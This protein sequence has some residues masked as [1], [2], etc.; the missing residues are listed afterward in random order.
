M[1]ACG[2]AST[3]P[4][5]DASPQETTAQGA[6]PAPS[7]TP[8]EAAVQLAL[9]DRFYLV[10]ESFARLQVLVGPRASDGSLLMVTLNGTRLPPGG[11]DCLGG[12]EVR[13]HGSRYPAVRVGASL[14][15]AAN[16]SHPNSGSFRVEGGAAMVSAER[17]EGTLRFTSATCDTGELAWAG[18][19]VTP[20]EF[21]A[22]IFRLTTPEVAGLFGLSRPEGAP[23]DLSRVLPLTLPAAVAPASGPASSPPAAGAS[24]GAG[25][26]PAAQPPAAY[27]PCAGR[28]IPEAK[29]DCY[30]TGQLFDAH[31]HMGFATQQN[32]SGDA[33]CR[34][35]GE[36]FTGAIGFYGSRA[37]A[38]F[39]SGLQER[40]RSGARCIV[41]LLGPNSADLAQGA[42]TL[43]LMRNAL[44]PNGSFRGIGEIAMYDEP[45]WPLSL[46]SPQLQDVLR[47]AAGARGIVMIHLRPSNNPNPTAA[48]EIERA[49]TAYPEVTF[50]FHGRGLIDLVVP[51]MDRYP[52]IYFSY[53]FATWTDGPWGDLRQIFWSPSS[54]MGG[55]Y[56][57]FAADFDRVGMQAFVDRVISI[58]LPRLEKHPDRIMFGTDRF[59]S[60]HFEPRMH[61][62]IVEAARQVIGRLPPE[63]RE[64]YAYGNALAA[65]GRFLAP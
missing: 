10:G 25:Q 34:Y 51:L 49:V 15:V 64:K 43:Q 38:T 35:P 46:D 16:G 61:E 50:F 36:G 4:P 21:A 41:P 23:P 17:L 27:A 22:V 40:A 8:A 28:P 62:V 26:P 7:A 5:E 19:F 45:L 42:Y 65:F 1:A 47:A 30:Y 59:I 6:A 9:P 31:L 39:V 53:D 20:E 14:A 12:G 18:G 24:G 60:W 2:G 11:V 13:V 57:Q 29:P 48:A 54:R 32:L 33:L 58:L 55:S 44:V 3:P 63:L 56:E 37:D 52:N